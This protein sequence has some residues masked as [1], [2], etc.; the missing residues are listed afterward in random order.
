HLLWKQRVGRRLLRAAKPHQPGKVPGLGRTA[1]ARVV[2]EGAE[3]GGREA[4]LPLGA[5]VSGGFPG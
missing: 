2:F 1:G 5:G 3:A 4:V